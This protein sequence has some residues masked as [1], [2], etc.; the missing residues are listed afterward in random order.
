MNSFL[1]ITSLLVFVLILISTAF[2]C[3]IAI[4]GIRT[5][6]RG[7]S[8]FYSSISAGKNQNIDVKINFYVDS[9]SGTD[10]PASIGAQAKIYKY[11]SRTGQWELH[12]STSIQ[13]HNLGVQAYQFQCDDAFNTGSNSD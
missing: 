11:N 5:E 1:K 2:A 10:C 12:T 13:T 8:D 9:Y 3:S 7:N 4:S 6:V